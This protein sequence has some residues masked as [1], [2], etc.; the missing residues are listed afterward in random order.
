LIY[1][2]GSD[3]GRTPTEDALHSKPLYGDLRNP[4][5]VGLSLANLDDF[6]CKKF[7]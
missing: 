6:A 7:G 5:R 1:N 3:R 2:K 4:C